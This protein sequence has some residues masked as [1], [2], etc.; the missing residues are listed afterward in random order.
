MIKSKLIKIAAVV[1]VLAAVF[2]VT[3]CENEL[4]PT[5][6]YSAIGGLPGGGSATGQT[7]PGWG[8]ADPS[9]TGR[10]FDTNNFPSPAAW[11]QLGHQHNFPDPFHF[12][13]G[14]KV[15]NLE[16][17]TNRRKEISSIVQYYEYGIM[18]PIDEDTIDIS[19]VDSG[20]ANCAI[21]VTH[22]ASGR[23]VSWTQNTTL[24]QT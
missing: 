24:I 12:A 11:N 8:T 10:R 9:Y 13:N 19:W 1:L 18:P 14:N 2:L 6:K 7:G 22:K 15:N 21:T 17:W 3:A 16:D 5:G 4:I 20:V 23:Q